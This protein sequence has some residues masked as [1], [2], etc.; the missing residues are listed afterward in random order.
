MFS[1]TWNLAVRIDLPEDRD[2][3]MPG[4]HSTIDLT[5]L[6]KMAIIPGQPFTIRE[7]NVNVA[8]G[9]ITERL[10]DATLVKGL[11]R[12]SLSTT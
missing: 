2:M 7:N 4:E 8:T 5:L 1:A 9:I 3:L 6:R 11:D 12:I 10:N